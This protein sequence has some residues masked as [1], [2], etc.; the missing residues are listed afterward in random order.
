[1]FT[2]Y[3]GIYNLWG[4]KTMRAIVQR[5]DGKLDYTMVSFLHYM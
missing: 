4:N 1:M 3:C 5:Q 2:M